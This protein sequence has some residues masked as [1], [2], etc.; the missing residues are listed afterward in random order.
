MLSHANLT[1]N[2]HNFQS[3]ADFSSRDTTW[4]SR[5]SS[6]SGGLAVTVLPT[7]WKGGCVLL[8]PGPDVE[9]GLELIAAERVTTMFR[10]PTCS[11]RSRARRAGPTRTCPAFASA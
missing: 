6:G 8:M 7:L 1:A 10:G 5:R 3:V 2:V 9:R 11:R 4:P